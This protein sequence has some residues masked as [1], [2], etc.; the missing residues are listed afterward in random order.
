MTIIHDF[1]GLFP[2]WE[3]WV[4]TSAF[5]MCSPLERMEMAEVSCRECHLRWPS[6]GRGCHHDL[7]ANTAHPVRI[8]TLWLRSSHKHAQKKV[9]RIRVFRNAVEVPSNM[10]K[11]EQNI[12]QSSEPVQRGVGVVKMD[13][14]R[15]IW[16]LLIGIT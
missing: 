12:E 7:E 11:A 3:E 15:L 10:K 2:E 16:Q 9:E 5:A 14:R 1:H 13:K 6:E 4:G 8:E